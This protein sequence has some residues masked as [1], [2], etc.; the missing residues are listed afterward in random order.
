MIDFLVHAYSQMIVL[1]PHGPLAAEE[2]RMMIDALLLM[3][4][5]VIPVIV[6]TVLICIKYRASNTQAKYSPNWAHG[7]LLEATWWTIPI[8]II[9]VLATLT[10]RETHALDPYKPLD[11]KVQPITIQVVALQWRW[12]FIYPQQNIATINFVE[13]PVNTPID[14]LITSDAPMNSFQIQGLAGQ[15]YAMNGMQTKLHVL[16][17][18]VGDYHGL[19]T[20]FSGDGFS[21]MNFIA[22]VTTQSTFDQW[23]NTVKHGPE[24]LTL[25]LY[26]QLAL[27]TSDASPHEYSAVVNHLFNE[28]IMSYMMPMK[29]THS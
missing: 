5:V 25:P 17:S 3:A 19:S 21:N 13:L 10:W 22:R 14:F 16:G 9:A 12:L 26:H 15:I 8:I 27:P 4:I 18:D 7:A 11:S 6:L 20:N 28:I 23:V 29:T 24:A 2:K 1:H